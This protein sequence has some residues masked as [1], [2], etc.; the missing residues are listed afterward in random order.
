MNQNLTSKARGNEQFHVL[1]FLVISTLQLT[2]SGKFDYD[3]YTTPGMRPR[4]DTGG[5]DSHIG[6]RR[7]HPKIRWF[8]RTLWPCGIALVSTSQ[9][10]M[11]SGPQVPTWKNH[12]V[13]VWAMIYTLGLPVSGGGRQGLGG[14]DFDTWQL[15]L[16]M[17]K[18]QGFERCSGNVFLWCDVPKHG[19]S[20]SPD[21]LNFF[22]SISVGIFPIPKGSGFFSREN[23]ETSYRSTPSVNREKQYRQI[24]GFKDS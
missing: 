14:F 4:I 11:I 7:V 17:K 21:L 3:P 2:I 12:D 15:L 24:G 5:V 1:P 18:A 10:Q 9:Y 22:Q 6:R 8:W 20:S 13:P 19:R 23:D 16:S